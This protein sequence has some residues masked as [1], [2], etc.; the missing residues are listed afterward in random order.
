MTETIPIRRS[1]LQRCFARLER[2]EYHRAL[3]IGDVRHEHATSVGVDVVLT[4]HVHCAWVRVHEASAGQRQRVARSR[5][6]ARRFGEAKR[7][8]VV[9]GITVL[10][11]LLTYVHFDNLIVSKKRIC[12]FFFVS[13][14]T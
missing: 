2:L 14:T 8:N 3:E 9:F 5:R 11:D 1:I 13:T 10:I 12:C 4:A 7:N 6:N